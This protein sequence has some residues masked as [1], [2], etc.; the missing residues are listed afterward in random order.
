[1]VRMNKS[2]LMLTG[3]PSGSMLK[4]SFRKL[5]LWIKVV[6]IF[7]LSLI[8]VYKLLQQRLS[9]IGSPETSYIKNQTTN[10]TLIRPILIAVITVDH[11]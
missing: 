9:Q 3:T 8:L 1:M 10:Q 6:S 11:I 5:F 4:K 7:S 2:M